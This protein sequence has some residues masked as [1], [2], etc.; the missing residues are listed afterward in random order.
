MNGHKKSQRIR[1]SFDLLPR[2]GEPVALELYDEIVEMRSLLQ[3][4]HRSLESCKPFSD[5]QLLEKIEQFLST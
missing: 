1:L 5:P 3:D 2:P 4:A